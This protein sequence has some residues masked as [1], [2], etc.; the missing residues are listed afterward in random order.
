MTHDGPQRGVVMLRWYCGAQFTANRF[1]IAVSTLL[2][3][4]ATILTLRP[5]KAGN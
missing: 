5:V 2:R 4:T 1:A 3:R